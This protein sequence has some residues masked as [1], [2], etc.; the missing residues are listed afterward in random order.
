MTIARSEHHD[1]AVAHVTGTAIYTDEQRL[2]AGMLSAYPV[3]STQAKATILSLDYADALNV[4]GCVAVVTAADIP[5]E[6]DTG[7]AIHDEVLLPTD[8]VSYW[9]QP[10]AWVVATTE[11][12]AKVAA[13]RVKVAYE[14]LPAVLS[15][16]EAIATNHFHGNPQV[17]RRGNL[18]NGL[19]QSEHRLTGELELNGQ[20]HFYL[21]TQTSWVIPDG[22][23][24]YQV[25][26]STQHPSETQ[27]VVARVLGISSNQVVV[28]CLRMGGGFGGKESQANPFAAVAAI[29]AHKTGCPVRIKLNRQQDMWITGKRHGFLGQYQVGFSAEGRLTALEIDL[30]SDG[31]WSL[32]LSTPV[33]SRAM[34]HIDN[35]YYSPNLEVRGRVTKTNKPSNTAFRGFGGPQGMVLIEEIIDRV[36][37]YLNLSPEIIRERNFYHGS[38]E[39][40]TTHYGQEIVDNRIA[41]VWQEV[42]SRSN[43]AE[44]KSAI[45]LFNQAH[46]HQ[47]RGLAITPV[48]FGISFT[49]K[50]YNQAGALVLIYADGSIQLN[51]GGTEMGQGLQ[52][53]MLQVAAQTLGVSLDRLRIMP[54]STD[55]VP[56]TSATAA[57]SGTDLNGQ[58][59][60][61]AC[62]VLQDRLA[63][64][65]AAMLKVDR[66]ERIIFAN[67]WV[68]VD[69]NPSQKLSFRQVVEKAYGDRI[70][71]SAT[72]YYRTPN[73]HWDAQVGKGTPFYY[74]A[75]GAAVSEVEVDGFTGTFKLRQVDIVQDVGQSLNPL[76]DHGQIA[77]GFVQGMGWL[78]MEEL[79]WDDQGRLRTDAPST[80]K[81]PTISEIPE[82]FTIHLLERAAQEGV[83]Y[84]SKAVGEPPLMLA[85]SVREAIRAAV[86]AFG[87]SHQVPLAVPAT[88]EATL[89]A[90]AFVRRSSE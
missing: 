65:A 13:S 30:Y 89:S 15:I 74:F 68:Y 41:R 49:K 82:A 86:A 90:I 29:A 75:Y 56:N 87:A 5:G 59:V 77:G 81:I 24:H 71:L 2:P 25:Y 50:E 28:T 33:L 58:A 40:N 43:V 72:G 60:K 45:A 16:S 83:I 35:A 84:G 88:P 4:E 22:E 78:T 17:M 14:P 55:K 73:I 64:V 8:Q 18:S 62:E 85:I 34:F 21:E 19:V 6:N 36:A 53:K 46:P 9:G 27:V 32:D 3:L 31:G 12:I 70:S 66:P 42:L 69:E 26:A 51:H 10:I 7:V 76:I 20:D 1:S 61:N 52:I 38:G 54:T 80:Y 57:S 48:K 11:A 44:R 47:K 67:D 37:R 63:I 39:T 79:V 23:G